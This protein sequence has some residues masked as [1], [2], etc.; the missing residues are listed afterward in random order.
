[1]GPDRVETEKSRRRIEVRTYSGEQKLKRSQPL[2]TAIT[3]RAQ[4][5]VVCATAV[6]LRFERQRNRQDIPSDRGSC[7]RTAQTGP[8]WRNES[9]LENRGLRS[10]LG[11]GQQARENLLHD[12]SGRKSSHVYPV[13]RPPGEAALFLPALPGKSDSKRFWICGHPDLDQKPRPRLE[14]VKATPAVA[15]QPS[16]AGWARK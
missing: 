12:A 10:S 14:I 3:A 1:M 13:H 16:P 4:V 5:P 6:R 2:R 11:S 15:D 9:L 7:C 8:Y